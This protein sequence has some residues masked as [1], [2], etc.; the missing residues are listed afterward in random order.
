MSYENFLVKNAGTLALKYQLGLSEVA[1]NTVTRADGNHDLREVLKVAVV[2]G[3][4]SGDREAAKTLSGYVS[5]KDFANGSA[6]IS[7]LE[8]GASEIFGVVMY[9]APNDNATDDLYNLN[10]GTKANANTSYDKDSEASASQTRLYIDSKI[11]LNATQQTSESDSFGRDYDASAGDSDVWASTS[12]AS[13]AMMSGEITG[14]E[15]L[16]ITKSGKIESATVPAAAANAVFSEMADTT[17]DGASNEMTMN[18]NVEKT[19]ESTDETTS[20]TTV[21]LEIDMTAVMKTTIGENS[22]TTTKDVTELSDYVTINYNLGTGKSLTGATHNGYAMTEL[23]S[24][25]AT[26]PAE[27]AEGY[28]ADG[29]Y[30]HTPESGILTI[31]TK[32]FS[33]FAVSWVEYV[34]SADVWDDKWITLYF[35]SLTEALKASMASEDEDDGYLEIHLLRDVS[36]TINFVQNAVGDTYASEIYLDGHT[37]DGTINLIGTTMT[38][39]DGTVTADITLNDVTEGTTTQNCALYLGLE[40]IDWDTEESIYLY[41]VTVS[42]HITLHGEESALYIYG[43]SSAPNV[44]NNVGHVYRYPES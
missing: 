16:E 15:S 30:Y 19:G 39:C 26:L 14:T 22:T 1:Y 4:F 23:A 2:T 3:G 32:S 34:A 17:T 38:I 7:S 41:P 42:G 36:E 35:T 6:K 13:S 29:Y 33:P 18:L 20:T 37:L 27:D 44:T 10:N 24:A 28:D 43:T 25:D 9:W 5:F 31:K 12:V 11:L 40:D 21:A 8:A